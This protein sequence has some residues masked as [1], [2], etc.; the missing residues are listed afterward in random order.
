[1]DFGGVLACFG[2]IDL[3]AQPAARSA[4]R[5]MCDRPAL[6][7]IFHQAATVIQQERLSGSNVQKQVPQG[8]QTMV[9][10]LN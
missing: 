9:S 6:P 2:P 5:S 3:R 1:V 4:Q 7:G 10:R 8:D